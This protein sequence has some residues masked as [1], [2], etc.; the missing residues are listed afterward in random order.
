MGMLLQKM[1]LNKATKIRLNYIIGGVICV[2]LLW[3]I[4]LQI[5]KQFKKIYP[6]DVFAKCNDN[7]ICLLQNLDSLEKGSIWQMGPE[8]LLWLAVILMPIN[9]A[10]EAR[11]WHLLAGSAQ[12]LSYGQ[13]FLSYLAGIAFSVVTPNR[14]G[15]Y[16]GRIIYLRRKNTFRLI[17]VSVL[18]AISQMLTLFIYGFLGLI[19]YNIA[20]PGVPQMVIMVCCFIIM[21]FVMVAYWSFERWAPFIEKIKWLRRRRYH[22][23]GRLLKR[24]TTREQWNI[25]GI[26]LVRYTIYTTQYILL[27]QW[28]G[29]TIP[30]LEGFLTSALFFFIVAVIPS[31]TLIE[32][33]ERGVVGLFLFHQF[34][35]NTVGIL[36][37]TLGVWCINL[38]LPA[39]V[40]SLLLFR[41]KLLR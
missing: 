20:N 12:P 1:N 11:K 22:I 37:A 18:G 10:L 27:L 40:G 29:V 17:S 13:S 16:P 25:L 30:F 32:L 6:P 4:Y 34:S 31:V 9:L 8:Y 35:E 36:A 7:I 38:I 19:Y 3:G 5:I 39:I 15:E 23:Y 2:L 21:V 24:F 26:S 28:M 41:M 33:G 14:L